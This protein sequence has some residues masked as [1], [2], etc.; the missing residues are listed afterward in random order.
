[1]KRTLEFIFR[2][3]K[4][5]RFHTADTLTTQTVGEHSFG[6]A[7]LVIL[8]NPSARKEL[9]LAALAH[10]LAEHVVGDVASPAKRAFPALKSALD[11]AEA[12]A[13]CGAGLDYTKG[14]ADSELRLLKYA[15]MLDGML[16]CVRERKMG[17]VVVTE[18]YERFR[19]YA[20]EV[21]GLP[22]SAEELFN[23]ITYEW[24]K[25]N[26]RE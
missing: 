25:V 12:L 18:I 22:P 4:T 19:Q 24:E 9:I 11:S 2:G 23:T 1:M 17:S 8:L 6:V 20:S 16:F 21:K 26:G 10:D 5:R 7:W 15:D 14:L 3:A 13:L